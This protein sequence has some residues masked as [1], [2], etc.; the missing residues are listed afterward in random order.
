VKPPLFTSKS[1]FAEGVAKALPKAKASVAK[2]PDDAFQKSILAQ[3]E[4]MERSIAENRAPSAEDL[5]RLN[6]GVIAV[7][8]LED[9]DP[10]YAAF[11][12]ELEYAFRRLK[13]LPP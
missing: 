8:T 13:T 3:L 1:Q 5:D 10:E 6:L 4:F 2:N 9:T 12:S 11:L 7:R